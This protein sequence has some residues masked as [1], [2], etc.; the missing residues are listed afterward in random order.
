MLTRI[1]RFHPFLLLALFTLGIM[2]IGPLVPLDYDD[3]GI[4]T[5]WFVFTYGLTTVFRYSSALA[6][7]ILGDQSGTTFT[8]LSLLLGAS[9][10]LG[11]DFLLSAWARRH[12]R[13]ES[14]A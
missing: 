3:N 9:V 6:G 2:V 14:T 4:G 7:E 11:A 12:K 10:Y 5:A 1:A 8:V 13:K